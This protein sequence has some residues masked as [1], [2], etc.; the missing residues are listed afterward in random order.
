MA[1][2]ARLMAV[3]V[4]MVMLGAGAAPAAAFPAAPPADRLD[5]TVLRGGSEMGRHTVRFTELD[6]GRLQVDV[7]IE[8]TVRVVGIPVFRY[9]HRNREIWDDNG[10]VRLDTVTNDDG[11]RNEVSAARMPDGTL[12]VNGAQ[13]RA[14]SVP[15]GLI[16]SSYW[17]PRL[18]EQDRMLNT[19]DGTIMA[20]GITRLG[21]ET[22]QAEGGTIEAT[23]YALEGTI[24]LDLWYDDDG[25][26]V[27]CAFEARGATVFY[28]LQPVRSASTQ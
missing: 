27:K 25:R 6:D 22:I 26:W 15:A 9:S 18:L 8:L 5:F 23:R 12:R 17:N 24:R 19:Q 16:P 28:E 10:L 14:N 13:G 1:D 4:T 2:P 21:R 3:M 20:I 7:E 11:S